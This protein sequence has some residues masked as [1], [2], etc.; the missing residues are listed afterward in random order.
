MKQFDKMKC[1]Q[2]TQRWA[3]RAARRMLNAK[4]SM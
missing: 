3:D 1:Q 4:S 2:L